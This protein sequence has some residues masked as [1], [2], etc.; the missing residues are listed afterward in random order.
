[1]PVDMTAL[2]GDLA[3]ETDGLRELV[4]PLTAE[5]WLTPTPA[6]HWTIADQIVHLAF[7]DEQATI[8]AT[9]PDRFREGLNE[10]ASDPAGFANKVNARHQD[11]AGPQALEWFDRA[12]SELISAMTKLDPSARVPWYGPDMSVASSMT[13]RIMET[14]AHGQD[15][16]DALG[17]SRSPSDRLR[18]VAFIGVRTV[19]NSYQARGMAPPEATVRA[20]LRAPSG[21]TWVF[22]PEDAADI[23]RGPALD[24]C[25]AVTQRRH[26]DDLNLELVGPV[27]S[28]WLSI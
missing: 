11:F 7:F 1:M 28:E 16:A 13:A 22:G 27:A 20:E 6:P 12:R 9:Q 14:W 23:V 2:A 19:P 17:V 10:M 25:L 21:D 24:F 3:A 15:I 4:A 26:L 5:G 18:H 8:A